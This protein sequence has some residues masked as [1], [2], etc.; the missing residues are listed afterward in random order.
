MLITL[1]GA[2][3]WA[4]YAALQKKL[5]LHYP[6]G[7]LNVFIFG[8][9]VLIYLPFVNFGSLLHLNWLTWLLLLFVGLNTLFSYQFLSMALKNTEANKVSVI[10][11]LNPIITFITMGIITH[12]NVSWIE[13]E[14]FSAITILGALLVIS[15]AILVAKKQ[16]I[17]RKLKN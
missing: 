15:G 4:I 14:R 6:V 10:I 13:H 8:L 1:T 12:L 11:I 17:S 2:V 7:M 9:P 5:V 16:K 3:A